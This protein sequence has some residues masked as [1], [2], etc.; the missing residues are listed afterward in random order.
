MSTYL[1]P[2]LAECVSVA[3]SGLVRIE[4]EMGKVR[5]STL[6]GDRTESVHG[7]TTAGLVL[8]ASGEPYAVVRME[9][10]WPEA[11]VLTA[12]ESDLIL[13]VTRVLANPGMYTLD[14]DT[15]KRKE[16]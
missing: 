15:I 4:R 2:E 10:V 3:A 7:M 14:G 11:S 13:A 16:R 9:D 8:A 6:E 12:E 5:G 1:D